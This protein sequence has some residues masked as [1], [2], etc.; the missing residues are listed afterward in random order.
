[1]EKNVAERE[2]S[3]RTGESIAALFAPRC[4]MFA[5][6]DKAAVYVVMF[7]QQTLET[8]PSARPPPQQ[9]V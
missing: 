2:A 5:A 8:D 6:I 9:I 4:A 3:L 1:M 7:S